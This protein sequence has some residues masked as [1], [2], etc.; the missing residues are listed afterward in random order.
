[1]GESGE[2]GSRHSVVC[3][4]SEANA[5]YRVHYATRRYDNP[6]TVVRLRHMSVAPVKKNAIAATR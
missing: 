4:V 1:M 6:R 3:E 2:A 5:I